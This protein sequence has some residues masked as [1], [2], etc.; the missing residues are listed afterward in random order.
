MLMFILEEA[1]GPLTLFF[2]LSNGPDFNSKWALFDN[3]PMG[4][5]WSNLE[6]NRNCWKL[7]PIPITLEQTLLSLYLQ[8][9]RK[10]RFNWQKGLPTSLSMKYSIMK[11]PNS[12]I[13]QIVRHFMTILSGLSH[14]IEWGFKSCSTVKLAEQNKSK[15]LWVHSFSSTSWPLK[16]SMSF[17]NDQTNTS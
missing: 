16:V 15:S 14:L 9:P 4:K 7:Y 12:F 10:T 13:V 11:C 3:M 2:L 5:F 1:M 8:I 6:V 17:Q